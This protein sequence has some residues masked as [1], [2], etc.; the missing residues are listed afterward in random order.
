MTT[1]M[2]FSFIDNALNFKVQLTVLEHACTYLLHRCCSC[3][4]ASPMPNGHDV[5]AL[6]QLST[7][8]SSKRVMS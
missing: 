1:L 2:P 7:H 6:L 3:S 8:M 5:D 4:T